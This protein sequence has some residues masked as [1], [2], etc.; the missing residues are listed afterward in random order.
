MQFQLGSFLSNKD[1]A[2]GLVSNNLDLYFNSSFT[3]KDFVLINSSRS[4]PTTFLFLL[5]SC[6]RRGDGEGEWFSVADCI[7]VNKLDS[8]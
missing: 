7:L 1:N 6:Y 5:N 3:Y 4:G 8:S 2:A